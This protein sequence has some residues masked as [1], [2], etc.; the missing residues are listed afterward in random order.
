M[1]TKK[2]WS[3]VRGETGNRSL[4]INMPSTFSCASFRATSFC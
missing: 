2:D 1:D 3:Y 4:E